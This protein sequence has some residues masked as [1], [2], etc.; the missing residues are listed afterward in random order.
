MRRAG[1][2]GLLMSLLLFLCVP[3]RAA[4]SQDDPLE[5]PLGE[6]MEDFSVETVNGDT[7]TL[8]EA[9]KDHDMVLINFWATWCPPCAYEFPF[10]ESAYEKYSDRVAV[11]ALS[12][13]PEDTDEMIADYV[14]EMGLTFPAGSDRELQLSYTYVKGGIPTSLVIDKFGNTAWLEVGAQS[15]ENAFCRLF[16]YFLSDEYTETTVIEGIPGEETESTYT[17]RFI[18]PEGEPVPGC[19]INFCTDEFC[20]PVTSDENGVA[21]FV[22]EPK[23]YHLQILS[24]PEGYHWED[25][26]PFYTDTKSEMITA[27][28]TMQ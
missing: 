19:V 5:V 24:V 25:G 17:V 27:Y 14:E 9:L 15:S 16:D 21:V 28:L 3:V 1:L 2:L 12:L 20:S 26:E 22:G 8:S 4:S 7:F 6:A 18:G 10:L 13:D 11:L 23:A